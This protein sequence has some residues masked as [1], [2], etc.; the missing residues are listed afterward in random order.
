MTGPRLSAGCSRTGCYICRGTGVGDRD[1]SKARFTPYI[2]TATIQRARA[3]VAAL[4][5][6]V[7][8][9]RS[10]NELVDSALR[11]ECARLERTHNEG[12]E[13]PP[14]VEMPGSGGKR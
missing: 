14:A 4:H 1:M 9:A 2:S 13:F 11:R 5:G 8:E 6:K 10:V 12:E 7:P 3:V